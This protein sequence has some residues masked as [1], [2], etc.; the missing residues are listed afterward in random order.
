M[1][2]E[3]D[4]LSKKWGIP[5]VE[6][7]QRVTKWFQNFSSKD[8]FIL[9]KKI[10]HNIDYFNSYRIEIAIDDV[11]N[12]FKTYNLCLEVLTKLSLSEI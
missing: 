12:Q 2:N 8:E 10:L 11:I 6:L 1:Y 4:I 7:E 5:K 3:I 9:A